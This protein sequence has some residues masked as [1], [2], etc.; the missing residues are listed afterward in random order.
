[1]A[2]GQDNHEVVLNVEF[3][4]CNVARIATRDDQFPVTPFDRPAYQG[5]LP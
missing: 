2:D 5:M 3:V 4:E 1:M